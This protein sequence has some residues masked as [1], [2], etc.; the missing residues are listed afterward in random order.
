MMMESRLPN[1]P[2]CSMRVKSFT[3]LSEE[4][5]KA[6]TNR[7]EIIQVVAACAH[8][9]YE[10]PISVNFPSRSYMEVFS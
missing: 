10:R 2:S 8:I 4:L 3:Y 6:Y 1:L 7:C 5:V 9:F